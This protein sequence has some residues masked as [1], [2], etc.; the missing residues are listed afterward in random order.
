MFARNALS[1]DVA[2]EPAD[3][4]ELVKPETGEWPQHDIRPG[5]APDLGTAGKCRIAEKYLQHVLVSHAASE[6]DGRHE[7]D[8]DEAPCDDEARPDPKRT[9][10]EVDAVGE[11]GHG[12]GK[13]E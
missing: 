2:A 13:N 10:R 8:K 11:Q 9:R 5:E 1:A 6:C 12:Q 3:A 4:P 7:D